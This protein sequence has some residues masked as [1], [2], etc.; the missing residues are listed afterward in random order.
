[1]DHKAVYKQVVKEVEC[2]D[3][4]GS[5]SPCDIMIMGENA[6]PLV[7][8]RKGHILVAASCYGDGKIVAIGHEAYLNNP[9]FFTFIRNVIEWMNP[10][11]AGSI[12][13][14]S[15]FDNLF[16][17]LCKKNLNVSSLTCFNDSISVYCTNAYF[18]KNQ[19]RD[20]VKFVKGG[21]GL[22]IG[23]Q[24]WHWSQ[25]NC[26]KK[27]LFSF[28]GNK[29]T[30]VAGIHFTPTIAENGI[31]YVGEEIP[32]IPMLSSHKFD[33]ADDLAELM[34]DVEEFQIP[35][36]FTLSS[37]MLHGPLAFPLGVD[38]SHHTL[39]AAAHY[40]KGRVVVVSHEG[41]FSHLA[42][43]TFF[44]N[45]VR[46]LDAGKGGKIGVV[47]QLTGFHNML[48]Q[49]SFPSEL[50]DFSE[51]LHVYCC[52][53]YSDSNSDKIHEFV[54]EGGGLLI[55]GHAWWWAYSNTGKDA[56]AEY[57]GNKILNKF[58]ITILPVCISGS[59]IKAPSPE[60]TFKS[61]HFRNALSVLGDHV[62]KNKE[63]DQTE[64][65]WMKKLEHDCRV[66]L[67]TT[68]EGNHS[69]TQI[70][71]FFTDL[72][73]SCNGLTETINTP[74]N[75]NSKEILL[76][77]IATELYHLSPNPEQ[78][79]TAVYK[80]LPELP[81]TP[82][83]E[84]DINGE[85]EGGVAWRSTGLYLSPA[86][87]VTITFP[88]TVLAAGLQVRIGC[89]SDELY[90]CK[91][92][93]RPPKV[94]RVFPVTEEKIT[95]STLWGGLIYIVLPEKCHVGQIHIAVEGAV[96][97]P[98]FKY[99]ETSLSDW[100]ETIQ[101]YPGPWAE[102]ATDELILTIPTDM[103]SQLENPEIPLALWDKIMKSVAELAAVRTPFPRP[104]RI[105]ADVQISAGFMHAG[106][107]IMMHINS[108]NALIDVEF[109]QKSGLWGSI[110]ELGHNQQKSNWEFSPHTTEATCNLWSVYVHENVLNIPRHDA[111][112]ELKPQQRENRI[113]QYLKK[114]AQ[115]T[116]WNVFTCLETYLQLQEAFGWDPFIQLFQ[117]YQTLPDIGNDNAAKM[118]RFAEMFSQK[119]QKNLVPF[120]TT[121]GWSINEDVAKKLSE[122]PDWD[123]NP[124]KK[125]TSD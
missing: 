24:A 86:S 26:S 36:Q 38:D 5:C 35:K 17:D 44:V 43:K 121:W 105:V 80:N 124:M 74:V 83:V 111:H 37:L 15:C 60:D 51:Q 56:I 91:M 119:I 14:Q 10:M 47:K 46:W 7:V 117:I 104:E 98:F 18:D 94:T 70:H 88:S 122:L 101:Q 123:E 100:K 45:A 99:G 76:Q 29:V 63:L 102:L 115:L 82:C 53:S 90:G 89:H 11:Q 27:A 81:T 40:G 66:T 64:V 71:Q 62:L 25:N 93:K 97:A 41:L 32:A 72:L 9:K 87:T 21:G 65:A 59:T 77:S 78:I 12:G 48:V 120:F 16:K 42:M 6:F 4:S 23:G 84:L 54:A 92:L 1:M 31:I 68:T 113:R 57:P 33:V 2:F 114:G 39:L 75:F 95:P 108:A 106:Y 61:Y 30:R 107:P 116:D 3:F 73:L 19:A 69:F 79:A 58:G 8:N 52:T 96:R 22:I 28:P 49:E 55:G 109:I 50:C 67:T 103:V 112:G 110:H 20:L 13:I 125:Y 85:N 34:E 118:N